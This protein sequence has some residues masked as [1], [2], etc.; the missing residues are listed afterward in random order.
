MQT[1]LACLAEEFPIFEA[2]SPADNQDGGAAPVRVRFEK[3]PSGRMARVRRVGNEATILYADRASATRAVGSL[4]SGLVEDGGEA[5]E[6][7]PFQTFGIMLD[8]SRNAVMRVDHFHRW[9][10]RLALLG[11]NLAMLYTED[12]YELPDE[13]H[14]GYGRGA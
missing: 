12:T 3:A 4:L 2:D 14:F 10:R 13:E 5:E 8:C 11:Y 9:L 6:H 1:I 7:S